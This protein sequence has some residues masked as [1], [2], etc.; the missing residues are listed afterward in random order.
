M[1]R[2][3]HPWAGVLSYLIP[4]LG[5]IYQG[6]LSKG[7]FFL[8]SLYGLFFVGMSLDDWK[9]VYI[10]DVRHNPGKFPNWMYN[11]YNRPQFIG[12]FWIGVAAWPAIWQYN[13]PPAREEP[14]G[15]FWQ[16]FEQAPK[17]EDVNKFIRDTDKTWDLGWIYTVIAG[18]LNILV[19]YDAFAGPAMGIAEAE[20]RPARAGGVPA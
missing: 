13:Q 17:E 3:F 19:I 20:V 11:L 6:R 12:Q 8:V 7:L 1:H 15:S 18:V 2:E 9:S 10:P 4:G 5:Q 16:Q 14:E